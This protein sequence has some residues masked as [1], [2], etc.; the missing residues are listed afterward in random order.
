M[1][2]FLLVKLDGGKRQSCIAVQS[3][4]VNCAAAAVRAIVRTVIDPAA[5]A[6]D[7]SMPC[8]RRHN[9]TW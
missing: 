1:P 5:F 8:F 4:V 7:R 9:R 3:M 2:P 6:A